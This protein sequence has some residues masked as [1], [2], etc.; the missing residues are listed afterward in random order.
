[1]KI[2]IIG[3]PGSG[4]E[5]IAKHLANKLRINHLNYRSIVK[6]FQKNDDIDRDILRD[7]VKNIPF[8]AKKAFLILKK[9]IEDNSMN[10]FVLDGYPKTI[11]EASLLSEF[12][13]SDHKEDNT[14]FFIDTSREVIENRLKNRLVCPLCSYLIYEPKESIL[15]VKCPECH[16]ILIKRRDDDDIDIKS[17]IERFINNKDG[18][19]SE[20]SRISRIHK[21]EGSKSIATIISDIVEILFGKNSDTLAERGARLLIEQIGLNLAD[22]NMIE[23][24][25]R[26]VRV[27]KEFTRGQSS[28]SC[29]IIKDELSTVFPTHYK[30]MIIL[31]PINCF[32]LCSHHLLPISYEISFGY[33]PA[34]KSLGFSKIIKVINLLAAK[35]ALQEDF[36][37]EIVETF[38]HILEPKG[39]MV[40]VRGKH[41]CMNI[42]GEKSNN[43]NIT[44]AV[45][46]VFKDE[47]KTREEFLSLTKIK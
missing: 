32:S 5:V 1:M 24:P 38:N 37:Q 46:G 40:I 17:R 34:E 11:E 9:F 2:F 14:T 45:R 25:A 12:F 43:Y 41:S 31:D 7:I 47:E 21:I 20:L 33:I 4:K 16:E 18:I 23:T 19:I 36:T 15:D 42:R 8:P 10:N 26:I 28:T 35:P 30:G 22:P 29:K 44:S 6:F 13:I 27:L 3:A 39:I